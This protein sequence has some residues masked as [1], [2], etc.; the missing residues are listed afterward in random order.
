MDLKPIESD[1]FQALQLGQMLHYEAGEGDKK[2]VATVKVV[3]QPA[4]SVWVEFITIETKR[5]GDPYRIGGRIVA[6]ENELFHLGESPISSTKYYIWTMYANA[7]PRKY[8][9]QENP[10][11]TSKEAAQAD[12]AMLCMTGGLSVLIRPEGED[13]NR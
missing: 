9:R 11:Y 13:P 3:G 7:R 4:V 5:T 12:W 2:I 10:T 8:I 1:V 6:S